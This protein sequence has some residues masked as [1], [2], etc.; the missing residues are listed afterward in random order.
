[1][2]GPIGAEGSGEEGE[3]AGIIHWGGLPSCSIYICDQRSRRF[4]QFGIYRKKQ[5]NELQVEK[6]IGNTHPTRRRLR[7]L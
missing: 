6:E 1:M 4:L 5:R 7:Q 3:E 2:L